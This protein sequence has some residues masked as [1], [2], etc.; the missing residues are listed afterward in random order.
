MRRGWSRLHAV[1]RLLLAELLQF[2]LCRTGELLRQHHLPASRRRLLR[3]GG[4]LSA[5]GQPVQPGR[6]VLRPE[7]HWK[8]MRPGWL[9]RRWH[10]WRLRRWL[11]LHRGRSVRLHV[12]A[13]RRAVLHERRLLLGQL[14]RRSVLRRRGLL[15]HGRLL[16]AAEHP[17]LQRRVLF[18]G[19]HLLRPERRHLLRRTAL[20]FL[21]RLPVRALLPRLRFGPAL[22]GDRRMHLRRDHLPGWLL[23]RWAGQPW[24][25]RAEAAGP[26]LPLHSAE[27]PQRVLRRVCLPH[28]VRRSV[29]RHGRG[30][31]RHLHRAGAVHRWQ[32]LSPGVR[33]RPVRPD[34]GRLW[35]HGGMRPVRSR[36]NAELQGWR[37]CQ[38]PSDVPECAL[39]PKPRQ[40]RHG[41]LQRR[42][43]RLR[44]WKLLVGLRL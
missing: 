34:L 19:Q 37:L 32:V 6:G 5:A 23:F 25:L 27:L 28:A 42:Q 3:G 29:L 17:V 9:R 14:L 10:V 41:L 4:M 24:D 31:V 44:S 18:P 40:W 11:H 39:L 36:C 35:G 16:P 1:E 12:A 26:A 20:R 13:G 43:Y 30:N 38:L 2:R 8:T 22:L 33:Q 15:L 7:L 21:Q